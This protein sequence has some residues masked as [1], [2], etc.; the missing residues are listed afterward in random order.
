MDLNQIDVTGCRIIGAI[1]NVL[2]HLGPKHHGVILGHSPIDQE[3][4]IAENMH[5]GYQISTY[6]DFQNRY[7]KNGEIIIE[8]ND[9]ELENI[10]VATRAI[11][12]IKKGDKGVYNLLTNNCES[13]VNRAMHNQ[14]KSNQIINTAIGVLVIAGLVYVI[15]NNK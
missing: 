15:R 6:T 4:Y 3:I 11:E 5:Y 2:G 8:P 14:S 1:D 13:F 7:S 10:A 12:E 9:G